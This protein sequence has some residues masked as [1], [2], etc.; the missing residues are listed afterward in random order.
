MKLALI[1]F[2]CIPYLFSLFIKF[3]SI[4]FLAFYNCSIANSTI[5][6]C[7]VY[8]Q[9]A[10]SNH[11]SALPRRHDNQAVGMQQDNY[12]AQ[13]VVS[14]S[15]HYKNEDPYEWVAPRR[16]GARNQRFEGR[17]GQGSELPVERQRVSNQFSPSGRTVMNQMY[18][19]HSEIQKLK[20]QQQ[21]QGDGY[22]SDKDHGYHSNREGYQR[23][24]AYTS[25]GERPR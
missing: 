19:D 13:R 4:L 22:R 23:E 17:A 11:Y 16:S 20:Q 5:L 10:D 24:S 21:M 1:F 2:Q 18:M 25:P 14:E 3:S 8:T 15:D 9:H 12:L 7:R 6:L